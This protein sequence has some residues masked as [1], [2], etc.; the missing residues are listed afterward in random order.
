MNSLTI[1]TSSTDCIKKDS[2]EFLIASIIL[3]FMCFT[4]GY[5]LSSLMT[6]R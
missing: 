5:V 2:P 1:F 3:A 6:R 4:I